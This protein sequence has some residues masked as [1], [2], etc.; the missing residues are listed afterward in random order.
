MT[1]RTLRFRAWHPEWD[2][3]IYSSKPDDP[4]AKREFYPWEFAV[5][6]SHYPKDDQWVIM[7]S[8]G[9][10][11]RTGEE[12]YEGDIL[13]FDP[14]EW[15]SSEGNRAV[16]EWASGRACFEC[17]GLSSDWPAWC[18]IVGNIYENGDS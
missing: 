18:K 7:Q 9:I 16:V 4:F 2:E 10:R 1:D 3:M 13:E 5:G 8:T 17:L 15:G 11:D 6:F 12:I 14:G